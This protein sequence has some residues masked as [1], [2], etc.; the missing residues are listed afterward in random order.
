MFVED[1]GDGGGI[2]LA[3]RGEQPGE[4]RAVRGVAGNRTFEG[5]PA[6]M[7]AFAREGMLN[8]AQRHLFGRAGIRANQPCACVA[9]PSR[10]DFSQRFAAFRR[11]SRVVTRRLLP[12]GAC[13]RLRQAG[14]RFGSEDRTR[15]VGGDSLAAD[16][17]RPSAR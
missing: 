7:T 14:R 6:L 3:G 1:G 10:S 12:F 2:S 15:W 8:V 13:V 5:D 11:L 17:R 16:R 4:R 9:S